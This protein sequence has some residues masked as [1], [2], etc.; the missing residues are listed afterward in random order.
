MASKIARTPSL[1]LEYLP[2][3]YQEDPF[4]G[5]FLSAFEKIILGRED[6]VAFPHKGVEATIDGLAAFFDPKETP[7]EF[8]PWLA[9]WTALS[10][11]ADLTPTKQRHFLEKIIQFYRWR[12]TKK[13]L[14]DLLELFTMGVPEV[15]EAGAAD[16]QIG[17][18]STLGKDTYIGG[19]P[20]HFFYVNISLPRAD[21]E[22]QLR[23]R[24]IAKAIIELE[25]PAHTFY[26]LTV[27]YPSMQIGKHSTVGVDTIL[28]VVE[29]S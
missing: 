14:Q 16:M 13:N 9:K 26:E 5:Q 18:Y 29:S 23:Q 28:G 1:L 21:P 12:G 17:V 19:G 25:K 22:V 8:L 3:I 2:A 27:K 6:D 24:E 4:V 20:Q 10:L 15:I 11:R 7:E